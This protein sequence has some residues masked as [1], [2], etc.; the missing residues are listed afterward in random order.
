M[1]NREHRE[2]RM[3]KQL[4][5]DVITRQAGSLWK[6]VPEA[7]MNA[8]DARA[9]R[10][11][12]T[13][14]RNMLIVDDNGKGFRE[15]D[16]I[17]RYFEVFGASHDPGEEKIFGQF[18]MGRGQLFAFGFNRWR[19][20]PFEMTIDIKKNGL[21]YTLTERE[22]FHDGCRIQIELYRQLTNTQFT[23]TLND[24]RTSAQYVAIPVTLNDKRITKNLANIQW[25][26]ATE[27]A[28]IRVSAGR[29]ALVVYN[30]GIRVLSFPFSRFGVGGCVVTKKRI[31]VN[32]ARNDVMEACP[33]WQRITKKLN[34]LGRAAQSATPDDSVAPRTRTQQS[35]MTEGD[36]RRQCGQIKDGMYASGVVKRAKL[37]TTFGR[38]ANLTLRQVYNIADG[39]VTMLEKPP[40]R[41]RDRQLV[42]RIRKNKL[43]CVLN[44]DMLAR[45]EV[46]S[47]K[48]L[49]EVVNSVLPRTDRHRWFFVPWTDVLKDLDSKFKIVADADL[50]KLEATVL[51]TLRASVRSLKYLHL[52]VTVTRRVVVGAGPAAVKTWTDGHSYIAINRERIAHYGLR[53]YAWHM[54]LTSILE[55]STFQHTTAAQ[56]NYK[57]KAAQRN[58][59]LAAL[60]DGNMAWMALYCIRYAAMV[61]AKL[62]YRMPATALAE[63]DSLEKAVAMCT[64]VSD[65][66]NVPPVT[67]VAAQP[68]NEGTTDAATS[69]P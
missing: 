55:Q 9:T 13:L 29:N 56:R 34:E 57:L 30:Q 65:A 35:A 37:F 18:R 68:Q 31:D 36:R 19:S 28:D 16:E 5:A 60:A 50:T 61:A 26:A 45:W 15:H 17:L 20:G 67:L 39:R 33:V 52:P 1:A 47:C 21:A 24:I 6:A 12:I 51:A 25:T 59:L 22:E 53:A 32:F 42:K 8:V 40:H 44:R 43:A 46:A 3:D 48:E 7:I 41:F 2:F 66:C 14:T 10:C 54:Y 49:V 58:A 63:A 11:D 62:G 23:Q 69:T 64:A 27:D 38:H 4:L